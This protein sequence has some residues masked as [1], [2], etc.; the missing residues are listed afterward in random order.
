MTPSVSSSLGS[1]RRGSRHGVPASTQTSRPRRGRSRSGVHRAHD[2]MRTLE[3]A[4]VDT[5]VTT[6]DDLETG[7]RSTSC[8]PVSSGPGTGSLTCKGLGRGVG[9]TLESPILSCPFVL[10]S[11]PCL[12]AATSGTGPRAP[13]VKTPSV[14]PSHDC[15]PGHSPGTLGSVGTF[16]PS[17]PSFRRDPRPG[18]R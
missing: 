8:T 9:V 6:T 4:T 12:G 7:T 5:G 2:A 14:C 3:G 1:D 10:R 18:A 13:T 17:G 15:P 11:V 16:L